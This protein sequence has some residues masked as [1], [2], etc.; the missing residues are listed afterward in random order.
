ME[1]HLLSLWRDRNRQRFQVGR[2][3]K[4]HKKTTKYQKIIIKKEF[5]VKEMSKAEGITWNNK[6]IVWEYKGKFGP[7]MTLLEVSLL[8]TKNP[9][10]K[11]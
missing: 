3:K 6:A 9:S 2:G 5:T 11:D 8:R 10:P 4:D 1:C 7:K